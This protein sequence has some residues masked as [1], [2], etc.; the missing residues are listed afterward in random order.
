[1]ELKE[2]L[3]KKRNVNLDVKRISPHSMYYGTSEYYREKLGDKLPD[4][5]YEILEAKHKK[6]NIEYI[7]LLKQQAVE[8]FNR[9]MIEY[10]ERANEGKDELPIDN[11]NISENCFIAK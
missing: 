4:I 8:E 9:L 2:A 10:E 6:Y 7:E 5:E 3:M 1:M 11:L